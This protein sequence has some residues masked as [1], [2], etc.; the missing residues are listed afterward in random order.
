MNVLFDQLEVGG[1]VVFDDYGFRG[2]DRVTSYVDT[3]YFDKAKINLKLVF[4]HN[5]NR[6]AILT[7]VS[8]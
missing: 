6:H 8:K 1:V 7:K 4:I 2:W 3:S 5:L